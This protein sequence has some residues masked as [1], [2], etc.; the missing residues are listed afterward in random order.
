MLG[1]VLA[2]AVERISAAERPGRRWF[3]M[4]SASAALLVYVHLTAL[5]L[6]ASLFAA[7]ALRAGIE[8]RLSG[9][10]PGL[11]VC[12]GA[13]GLVSLLLYLPTLDSLTRFVGRRIGDTAANAAWYARHHREPGGGFGL[14]DVAALL[15][16]SPT[17]G[18]VWIFALGPA[19]VWMLR[20][21][22]ARALLPVLAG[23]LPV[24]I[25]AAFVLQ[26]GQDL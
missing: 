2:L 12:V 3:L 25:V 16:G 14:T 11:V 7:A 26:S 18:W 15:A 9:A 4:A 21:R 22:G 6:V 20:V 10:W 19:A 23:L 1:L 24:A 17:A 13:A 5:A 8:R